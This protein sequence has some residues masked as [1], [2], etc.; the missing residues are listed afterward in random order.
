[1]KPF[2]SHRHKAVS[3]SASASVVYV[4][5]LCMRSIIIGID[6]FGANTR[7]TVNTMHSIPSTYKLIQAW[8]CVHVVRSK[9][10]PSI[11]Q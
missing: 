5:V 2:G 8:V 10:Y 7:Q 1:M 3:N 4:C 9:I 6:G 11:D